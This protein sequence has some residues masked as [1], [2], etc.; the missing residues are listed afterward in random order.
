MCNVKICV[1]LAKSRKENSTT[2]M[3]AFLYKSFVNEKTLRRKI[4]VFI[5][6]KND[7]QK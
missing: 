2:E 1:T 3:L 7:S 6:I 4:I 5:E